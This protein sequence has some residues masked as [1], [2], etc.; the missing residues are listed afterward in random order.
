MHEF[1]NNKLPNSFNCMFT[2]NRDRPKAR[3]TRQSDLLYEAPCKRVFAK[4]LP[5]YKYPTLYGT[6]GQLELSYPAVKTSL[7]IY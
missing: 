2:L 6:I 4:R 5:T 1:F 7:S 3:E